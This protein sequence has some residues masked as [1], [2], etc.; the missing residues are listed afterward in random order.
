MRS[1][2]GLAIEYVALEINAAANLS[3]LLHSAANLVEDTEIR[4]LQPID[5]AHF[6]L[7]SFITKNA[8]THAQTFKQIEIETIKTKSRKQQ[9]ASSTTITTTTIAAAEPNAK[10]N[11][12][13]QKQITPNE[14]EIELNECTLHTRSHQQKSLR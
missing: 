13:V 1:F 8:R 11:D 6:A 10:L 14:T 3:L 7:S 5:I 2:I 9:T 12:R 4:A